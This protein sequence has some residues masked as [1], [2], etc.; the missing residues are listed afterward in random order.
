MIISLS[1]CV[2]Y[3]HSAHTNIRQDS[4]DQDYQYLKTESLWVGFNYAEK[5]ASTT[6]ASENNGNKV[7]RPMTD[8]EKQTVLNN[9]T[10]GNYSTQNLLGDPVTSISEPTFMQ[11]TSFVKRKYGENAVVGNVVWDVKNTIFF[12]NFQKIES[13]TFDVYLKK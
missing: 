2:H 9:I 8:E 11:L 10:A 5:T 13:V 4:F 12:W 7:D 3:S 6:Q 1:G